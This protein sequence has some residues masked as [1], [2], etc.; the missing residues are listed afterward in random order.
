MAKRRKNQVEYHK[1][2]C[3]ITGQVYKT[4]R[5]APNPEELMSVKAYYEMH[6]EEDDRPAVIKK[7]IADEEARQEALAD[8]FAPPSND[9]EQT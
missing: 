7:Q 6:P 4:T 2:E 5:K 9:Q 3:N 8:L 1:Y